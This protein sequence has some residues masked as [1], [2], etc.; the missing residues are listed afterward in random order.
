MKRSSVTAGLQPPLLAILRGLPPQEALRIGRALVE[1]GL[2]LLEVPLNRPGALDA[3]RALSV[4]MPAEVLIGA[5]TVLSRLDVDA[6]ARAGGRLVV[7]PHCDPVVI[8]HALQAGLLCVPGIATPTEAFTALDAGAQ[9]L[10]VFP[11]EMVRPEGLEALVAVL[12]P[13][14]PVWPVGGIGPAS[15]ARWVQAGA[16]G[17][18]L[19]ASLY[20]PGQGPDDVRR[21]AR[22]CLEAWRACSDSAPRSG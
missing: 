15:M 12:P 9:V 21:D 18:G 19:G 8:R 22:A 11:A 20:R 4:E 3:I 10:K 7:S 5:G 6:V 16:S 17:F 13:G 14:T 1:G 2:R